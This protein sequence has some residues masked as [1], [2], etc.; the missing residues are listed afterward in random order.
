L[1]TS[2]TGALHPLTD[3]QDIVLWLALGLLAAH[4]RPR[5]DGW[6]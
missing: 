5:A 3:L 6:S 4:G 2:Y 1:A